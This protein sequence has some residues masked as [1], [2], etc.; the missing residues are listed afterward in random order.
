MTDRPPGSDDT[1]SGPGGPA[2]G[3]PSG[4]G[5]WWQD[6]TGYAVYLPSFAD[7]DGDGRGDLDGVTAHLDHLADL[8]VDLVWVSP[9]HPSPGADNGYDVS[10][11][12]TVDPVAGG[13][14][15]VDRLLDAA[16]RLGMR[17]VMDLVPNHT[18]RAHPWFR[19]ALADPTG[20]YRDYYVWADPGPDGGPP[21]NWVSCF[22]G[23]AWTFDRTTRQYYLHLFLPEQPDLNWRN[24]A[25][26][27]HFDR[28]MDRWLD[29]GFDGFRIDVAQGLV[30]DA[31]L[32]SNPVLAPFDPTAPRQA[33]WAAFE[34]R[35]DIVQPESLGVFRHWRRRCDG[36]GAL[37]LG[38]TSVDHAVQYGRLLPGDGLHLGFWLG[39]LHT[40]WDGES[41]RRAMEGPL[42][43]VTDPAS[44]A[45]VASSLDE[46]R[47]ATRLGGGDE[48]RRRALALATLLFCLPGVPFLYQGEELGLLQGDVPAAWR[49]DP[50]GAEVSDGR[51]GCRT[52]MPWRPGPNFGFSTATRTWLPDGGR[53]DADTATAQRGVAG[54]WYERYRALVRLRRAT[55]ALRQGPPPVWIDGGG[56]GLVA[57]RRGDWTVAA[58]CAATAVS[59]DV[60]GTVV[61]DSDRGSVTGEVG[62]GEVGAGEVGA[63]VAGPVVVAPGQ[64]LIVAPGDTAR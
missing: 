33:Q 43:A 5:P 50:V 34:H 27:A 6:C 48:G 14:D 20:P 53:T 17:V 41:I 54:S 32:R 58:N 64:A 28:I 37:L 55:P 2:S 16:H 10:D 19:A 18:S 46:V 1:S 11:Y 12:D 63:G 36:R 57:F 30:K 62:A 39:L 13:L 49:H 26:V 35:H 4:S 51:D 24:P 56:T 31:A 23:P 21:N 52:P 44:V 8:G 22:G 40:G 45:W 25:V 59:L 38:E 42:A 47:A 61:F 7:A 9:F 3:A 60:A 15:A 29:R